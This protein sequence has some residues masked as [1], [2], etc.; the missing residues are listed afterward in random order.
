MSATEPTTTTCTCKECEQFVHLTPDMR[1]TVLAVLYRALQDTRDDLRK[2]PP[3]TTEQE[4]A[5]MRVF[6]GELD[7]AIAH[8]SP[9]A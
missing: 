2:P 7:D 9:A 3:F 8:L 4:L 6:A 5:D 1:S